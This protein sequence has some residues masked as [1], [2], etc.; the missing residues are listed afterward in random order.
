MI[1]L[2]TR[3][4]QLTTQPGTRGR[5]RSAPGEVPA[6]P[7]GDLLT[8]DEEREDATTARR[9][10]RH[11]AADPTVDGRRRLAGAAPGHAALSVG[12]FGASTGAGAALAAAAE[13]P[14][15]VS[16]VVSQASGRTWRATYAASGHGP[17]PARRRWRRRGGLLDLQPGR[18]RSAPHR[19]HVV[20]GATHLFPEPGALAQVTE[21]AAGW[22]RDHVP[23]RLP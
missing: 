17:G 19:I 13:R 11:R 16:A 20:P 15:R 2:R 18:P 3:Q 23:G 4:R 8:E 22:F 21:A 5:R 1:L 12:L 10:L 9:S 7:A 6:A 14:N